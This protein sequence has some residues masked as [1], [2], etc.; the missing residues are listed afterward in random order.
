MDGVWA[1]TLDQL[2]SQAMAQRQPDDDAVAACVSQAEL[3]DSSDDQSVSTT[4][5]Q[6]LRL[7]G[8]LWMTRGP[9]VAEQALIAAMNVALASYQAMQMPGY[10]V[11]LSKALHERGLTGYSLW[12]LDTAVGIELPPPAPEAAAPVAELQNHRGELLRQVGELDNAQAA[13]TAALQALQGESADVQNARGIVLNNLGLLHQARGDLTE[14]K[15]HLISSLEIGEQ[16]GADPLS[17]AVT[18]DNLG[19][20]EAKIAARNGPLWLDEHYVNEAVDRHLRQA[21]KYFRRAIQLFETALPDSADD[22]VLCLLNTAD[23][24]LQRDDGGELEELSRRAVEISRRPQ[25]SGETASHA[26][27]LRGEVLQRRGDNRGVVD[28][29]G[30]WFEEVMAATPAHDRPIGGFIALLKAAVAVGDATLAA[31]V[32]RGIAA[33]DEEMLARRIAG[34]SEN[35]A[36]RIFEAYGDRTELVLGHCLPAKRAGVAPGWLYTLLLNRKGVLAER[37]GAAWLA[38][39][40]AAGEADE[41]VERIRGLRSEVARLDLDG[42]GEQTITAARRRHD[43]AVRRLGEAEQELYATA[44]R[45]WLPHITVDGVQAQLAAGTML[46]DFAAVRRLDGRRHH[47]VFVLTAEGPVRYRDLGAADTVEAQLQQLTST[48]ARPPAKNAPRE[49]WATTISQVAPSLFVA[50]EPVGERIIVAPTGL[51]GQAPIGLLPDADGTPLIENHAITLVPSGRWLATHA[52]AASTPLSLPGEPVV[53]G[54]PDF[55]REFADQVPFFLSMRFGR[56][57]Q[58]AAELAEVAA[59][60]GVTPV[61]EQDA[62]RGRLLEVRS[63]R[64][65]H[66]ATHGVFLDA[67][68]SLAEQSE[69]TSYTMRAVGGAVVS[70]DEETLGWSY[71][72][73]DDPADLQARHLSRVRWL[74][75]IGPASQL[76][77]SALLLSGFN[78]WVAGVDTPADVGTGLLSAAEFAL[79]DLSATDM[80][81]LSA[82]ETGVSAVDFADGSLLGLRSAALAAGAASC[83]ATLW[84]VADASSAALMSAF[85]RHLTGGISTADA[86]RAAQKD[87]RDSYPDPYHWAGWVLEVD[88]SVRVG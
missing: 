49:D 41:I 25:V 84:K 1:A 53:F 13:F 85:Y 46:L 68:A 6:M 36:R 17:M 52:A 57:K 28:L 9:Q 50:G 24:A 26:L 11:G 67:I 58:A 16:I 71:A 72:E 81:V 23:V 74:K 14:A 66:I 82:C 79:L 76:S 34:A 18:L 3:C 2:V 15:R 75:T 55:D 19:A 10:V 21:D 60:L 8:H 83:V 30:P 5:H 80:V 32:G 54:D 22:Y 88:G 44:G 59:T 33:T 61:A 63:P 29:L 70:V 35:D 42:S 47:V 45:D 48:F 86:L 20:V 37:Q 43:E 87:V 73:S 31:R 65:L 12:L 77:R 7:A 69:P 4:F 78:A 64:V 62:T 51:W 40:S 27:A 38:A 39:R 56:L